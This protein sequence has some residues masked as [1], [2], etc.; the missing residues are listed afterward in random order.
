M[1][2][3][4]V[5]FYFFAVIGL[6]F[7]S[8]GLR[9]V[10]IE[11]DVLAS[12]SVDAVLEGRRYNRGLRVHKLVSEALERMRWDAFRKWNEHYADPVD[13]DELASIFGDL[14][15]EISQQTFNT[16]LKSKAFNDAEE[17]YVQFCQSL[18]PNGQLWSSYLDIVGLPTVHMINT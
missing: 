8:A 9:D 17:R 15:A 18:G 11:A 14:R 3:F 1:G 16:V 12:G 2:T 5:V 13:L 7:G 6:R 4:H 10:L